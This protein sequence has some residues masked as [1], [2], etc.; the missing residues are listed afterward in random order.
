MNGD[1][2][3]PEAMLAFWH[4]VSIS[5]NHVIRQPEVDVCISSKLLLFV[6][7][8]CL[9][10]HSLQGKFGH[11][12]SQRKRSFF[13][14][15]CRYFQREWGRRCCKRHWTSNK[16]GNWAH[17]LFQMSGHRFLLKKNTSTHQKSKKKQQQLSLN[18]VLKTVKSRLFSV[19]W[20]FSCA[21]Q[22]PWQ[23]GE[24]RQGVELLVLRQFAK[25][26]D[27]FTIKLWCFTICAKVFSNNCT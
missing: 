12:I 10:L 15:Y 21:Q 7:K 2:R 26:V 18:T 13:I 9:S 6:I 8:S 3:A 24:S 4:T 1:L 5:W 16:S 27:L 23:I 25:E 14:S 19:G 17:L 11:N 22:A 20:S